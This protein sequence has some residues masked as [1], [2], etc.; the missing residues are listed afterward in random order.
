[1]I[2][3]LRN[4][5]KTLA[6][7]D[8]VLSPEW[9]YRYFSYNSNWSDTEEMASMRDGCGNHW[10]LWLCGNLAGYKCLSLDDGIMSDIQGAKN[11]VP[12]QYKGFLDEPAFTMDEAT[13]IWHLKESQWVKQGLRVQHLI[14]LEQI[15]ECTAGQYHSWATEYYETDIDITGVQKLFE[16]QFSKELAR[17]LNPEVDLLQLKSEMAEIGINA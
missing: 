3:K 5:M 13:C 12:V 4:Q 16:K 2:E 6:L 14:D 1:M 9:E 17:Q 15:S 11:R 10:F 8:A 7:A